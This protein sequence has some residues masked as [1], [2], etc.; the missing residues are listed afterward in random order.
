METW[1]VDE[2][3]LGSSSDLFLLSLVSGISFARPP[4]L[5]PSLP[6]L[7]SPAAPERVYVPLFRRA[8]LTTNDDGAL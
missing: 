8:E 6:P 2:V 5:P 4:P 1:S 7:I 3:Y